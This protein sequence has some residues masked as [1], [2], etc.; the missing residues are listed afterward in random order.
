MAGMAGA[1]D[2]PLLRSWTRLR[3]GAVRGALGGAFAMGV[4]PFARALAPE[5]VSVLLYHRIADERDSSF[6]G[7]ADN[8]SA[9]RAQF[10]CQLDY[11]GKTHSI[12]D[13]AAFE[14]WIGEGRELPR[15]P[16]LITFD[17][18]YGD[19]FWQALP[20]LRARGMPAVLFLATGYVG[21]QRAFFWDAVAEGFRRTQRREAKLPL[22]GSA[23]L[24]SIE[25][26]A[27]AARAWIAAAKQVDDAALKGALALLSD[28]LDRPLDARPPANTQM[29]WDQLRRLVDG[30]FT[31]CPHTV[32]HPILPRVP[33]E[34]ARREIAESRREIAER[35]GERTRTFAY[36]NGDAGAE[37]E[38]LLHEEGFIA[39]FRSSGGIAFAAEARRD[40]F[41]L[42][43]IGVTRRDDPPRF[44]AK[45]AGLSRLSR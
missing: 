9:T 6:Y 22:T 8:V 16:A 42:R 12:I 30:G 28:A 23:R 5:G 38:R 20:E 2:E 41:A 29:D 10:A 44:A 7:F 15:N 35:L 18:G 14:A 26:R 40:P 11:L 45:L 33:L 37:H 4:W 21:D 36:P 25:E 1:A 39:A 19:N 43:R 13:L 3:R 17:D 31:I 34:V 32:H 24:E 27:A